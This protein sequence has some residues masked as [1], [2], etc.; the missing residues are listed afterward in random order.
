MSPTKVIVDTQRY[1]ASHL[2]QPRGRGVWIFDSK[3]VEE[4]F[5]FNGLYG[6]AKAAA[7]KWAA[8]R[9]ITVIR[10]CP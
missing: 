4:T 3:N 10:T 7:C 5:T 6:E 1:F 9:N 8:E 2:K